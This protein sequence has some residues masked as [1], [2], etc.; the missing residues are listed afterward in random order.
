M[1]NVKKTSHRIAPNL[2]AQLQERWTRHRINK[3]TQAIIKRNGLV[4]LSGPFAGMLY[5]PEP[6][7]SSL[8]KLLG[9]YE[10]EL[11]QWVTAIINTDYGKIINVGCAEGYYSV[12]LALKVPETRVFAF[13]IDP[14]ARQLCEKMARVNGVSERVVVRG[15][16]KCEGLDELLDDRSLVIIDCE[17]CELA[18]LDPGRVPNLRVSDVL[19]ELHDFIDRSIS[20]TMI[21]RFADTHDIS[22][23]SG[24][25][26]DP[27]TYP[28]L[29]TFNDWD[30]HVAVA[31]FRPERMQ[32]AFMRA[33]H[34]A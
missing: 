3:I 21:S 2:Y 22:I 7:G 11:H 30:R 24:L 1:H 26:R 9:S 18:L 14:R 19:V 6:G 33:K 28:A 29:E 20:P 25:E 17:G 4:V 8:P 34:S 16:C 5:V 12:G 27:S 32:W 15:E 31:E 13:D 23:V 10:A